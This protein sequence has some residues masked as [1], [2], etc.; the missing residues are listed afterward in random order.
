METYAQSTCFGHA[1]GVVYNFLSVHLYIHAPDDGH[2]RSKHVI[3]MTVNDCYIEVWW[4]V[5]YSFLYI[6]QSKAHFVRFMQIMRNSECDQSNHLNCSQFYFVTSLKR[7]GVCVLAS[8]RAYWSPVVMSNLWDSLYIWTWSERDVYSVAC[9]RTD[10]SLDR[11]HLSQ[12]IVRRQLQACGCWTEC[13]FTLDWLTYEVVTVNP[14][15][16]SVTRR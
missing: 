15:L 16:W 5:S 1:C 13:H 11:E 2:I 10:H 9:C 3:H 8:K 4:T 14:F 6:P 7:G 12:L